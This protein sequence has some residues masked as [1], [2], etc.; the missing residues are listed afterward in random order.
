MNAW[1]VF[2]YVVHYSFLYFSG[3][4]AIDK[5]CVGPCHQYPSLRDY[6]PSARGTLAAINKL[7]PLHC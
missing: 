2:L 7:L 5:T 3:V 4:L 6:C 1:V